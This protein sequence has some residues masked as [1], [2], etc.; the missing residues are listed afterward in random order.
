VRVD[1][2]AGK[3]HQALPFTANKAALLAPTRRWSTVRLGLADI[4]RHVIQ[5]IYTVFVY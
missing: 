1:D 4:S 5:C 2:V 3:V